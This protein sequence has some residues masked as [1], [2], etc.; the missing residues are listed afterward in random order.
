MRLC[1]CDTLFHPHVSACLPH[2]RPLVFR[3]QMHLKYLEMFNQRSPGYI[4]DLQKNML[5]N[6]L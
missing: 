1:E 2:E 6:I 4:Q 5:T 3:Y